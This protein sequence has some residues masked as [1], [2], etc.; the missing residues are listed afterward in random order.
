MCN[1]VTLACATLMWE[2]YNQ[3]YP[4]LR[5]EMQKYHGRFRIDDK[6]IGLNGMTASEA[7]RSPTRQ[8][9]IIFRLLILELLKNNALHLLHG[10]TVNTGGGATKTLR[11][12]ENIRYI[13]KMPEPLP[14]FQLIHEEGR[15]SW[16]EMFED[17][18]NGIAADIIGS[19]EGGILE[20]AIKKV[21]LE[22]D[23]QYHELGE[24]VYSQNPKNEVF[25]ETDYGIF[26]YYGK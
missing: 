20:S 16:N 10:L 21:S 22:T 6:P 9:A 13:K 5:H 12:G 14:I 3:K 19:D 15:V 26:P 8:M 18:N 11:L 4:F 17:F 1:G 25:L 24:C 7:L 23:V 2:R